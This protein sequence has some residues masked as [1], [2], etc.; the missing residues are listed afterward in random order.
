MK[1]VPEKLSITR[2]E[3][4]K[5]LNQAGIGTSVHFIPLHIM[6]Y[7]KKKYNF[8]NND[9]PNAFLNYQLSISIPIYPDLSDNQVERI[10][11]TIKEIGLKAYKKK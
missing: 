5:K 3:F 10:I 2:D 11:D 8:K 9:F 7:Y 6:T 4:I 1:I